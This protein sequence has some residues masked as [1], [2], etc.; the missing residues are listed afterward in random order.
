MLRSLPLL[1]LLSLVGCTPSPA[2]KAD[3]GTLAI[4]LMT[5][6]NDFFN[7]IGETF[8]AEGEKAG[9]KVIVLS[10]DD[11]AKQHN[12]VKDFLV[13]KVRAIVLCPCDSQAVGAAIRE[14]NAAGVPVFTADLACLDPT[15]KVVTHVATDNF[16]GGQEAAKAMIEAL[17]SGGKVAILDFQEAESCI[18]RVKGFKEAIAAHNAKSKSSIAIIAEIPCGGNREK[19]FNAAQTLVTGHPDLVGIFAIN[20]PSALGACSAIDLVQ[21]TGQVKVVGFDGQ[22]D[23]KKAIRDGKIYADPVQFPDK[24]AR[25]TFDAIQKYLAGEKTPPEILIPTGLYRQADALADPKVK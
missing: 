4:S 2:P 6:Q 11:A 21:K 14:A 15:A 17:P 20:D 18:Q 23:G 7:V 5:A 24:I 22:P 8:K 9:Y 19:G 25:T 12:Q 3:K 1:A 13:Q 16:A 10:G